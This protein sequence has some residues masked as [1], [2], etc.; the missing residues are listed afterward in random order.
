MTDAYLRAALWSSTDD[1]EEPLDKEYDI[2]DIAPEAVRKAR[3][4]VERFFNQAG[5]LLAGMAP[6]FVGHNFWLTRNHHGTGFWDR[7]LG[8]KGDELTDLSHRF[9]EQWMYVGDDGKVY[10][11]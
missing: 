3:K 1:D 5:H 10:L 9:G 4:D 7:D 6:D 8:P 11:G 2:S